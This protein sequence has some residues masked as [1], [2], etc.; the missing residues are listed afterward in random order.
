MNDQGVF[1]MPGIYPMGLK[2]LQ[3]ALFQLQF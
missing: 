2:H 1:G 3:E